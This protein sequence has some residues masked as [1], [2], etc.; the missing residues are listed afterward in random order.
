MLGQF[1]PKDC[2]IYVLG[3]QEGINDRL[4]EAIQIYTET[5][6]LP[7]MCHLQSAREADTSQKSRRLARAINAQRMLDDVNEGK[8]F[9]EATSQADMLDRVW[10]RGDGAF[11]HPKFTG[12]AVFVQPVFAPYVRLLGV[13]KHA[14]GASEGSKGGAAVALGKLRTCEN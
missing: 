11:I 5:F 9:E 8:E 13:Y 2:D 7:L 14:F 1:I 10:G 3:V 6:Q 12:I 4:Y